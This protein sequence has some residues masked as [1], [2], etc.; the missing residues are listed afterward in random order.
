MSDSR[1]LDQYGYHQLTYSI[2]ANYA[3]RHGYLIR[4]FHTPCLAIAQNG[5]K[6]PK[7]C[8]ACIHPTHGGR[9]S[10]WCKLQALNDTMYRYMNDVD[11]IVYVD[12][13][14]FVN[15]LDSPFR[16]RYFNKTL[17]MFTNEGEIVP[18]SGIQL[19]QNTKISREIVSAWWDSNVNTTFNTQH[20]YEQS[21]FHGNTTFLSRY[22]PNIGII[23]ETVRE[24][25][26]ILNDAA[27][28]R[29][30]TRKQDN[31]RIERMKAFIDRYNITQL[32]T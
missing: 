8:I 2:N 20:D 15:R 6:D 1:P 19:W 7:E 28:F 25:R 10:P 13:D 18:C 27:F 22:W 29:H 14:V 16:E 24:N 26:K 9:M 31:A 11:R 4:Y 30:V 21:V 5:T 12:S 23:R 32:S 3:K 17:S